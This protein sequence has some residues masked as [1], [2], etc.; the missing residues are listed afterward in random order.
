MGGLLSAPV[1]PVQ[2]NEAQMMM[3]QEQ[4]RQNDLLYA[5]AEQTAQEQSQADEAA[6]ENL[7]QMELRD[8]EAEAEKKERD[9]RAAKGKKDLLYRNAVGVAGEDDA[10]GGPLLKL[11]GA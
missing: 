7:R 2:S 5:Q 9:D 11:G 6:A 10:L 3:V 4:K 1:A 8:A